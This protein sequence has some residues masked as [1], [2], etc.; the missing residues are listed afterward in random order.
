MQI[1]KKN[2]TPARLARGEGRQGFTLIELLVV[3]AI[4]A[5]LAAM[6]LPV[7]AK[8]KEKANQTYCMNNTK[9]LMLSMRLYA[10]DN[11][12]FLPPNVDNGGLR[13]QW[14]SGDMTNQNDATNTTLLADPKQALLAPYYGKNVAIY[15]C[16]SDKS[17]VTIAGI[18][19]PRVRSVSMSQAVG[20]KNDSQQAVDGPW[21]DGGHGHYLNETWY[22]YGKM[23]QIKFPSPSGLWVL[24]DEDE[25]SIN[26]AGLAVQM[27][28][29]AWIDYFATHH[30]FGVGIAFA[31]GHS[32]IH[33]WLD[34][35]TKCPNPPTQVTAKT[36]FDINW[37]QF[38][39]SANIKNPFGPMPP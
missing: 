34:G 32:E 4:I 2:Q 38:R 28:S 1:I 17:S 23:S 33:K 19:V 37:V 10:D 6:L 30:N 29:R 22:T 18:K 27:V 21:L 14:V 24:T 12:D 16:P 31:D 15:K 8:A 36:R 11:T 5:I 20:T 25:L 7:L 35:S 26:D 13:G 39:T 9:E 3:I